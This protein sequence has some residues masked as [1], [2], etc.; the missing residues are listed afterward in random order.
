MKTYHGLMHN[1]QLAA[2]LPETAEAI[3]AM[4]EFIDRHLPGRAQ[5]TERM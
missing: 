2:H 4:G 3:A 5:V 1:F